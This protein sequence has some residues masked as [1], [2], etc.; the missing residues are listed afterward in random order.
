MSDK[1][2]LERY[3]L[4]LLGLLCQPTLV[5]L[6]LNPIFYNHTMLYCYFDNK[7]WDYELF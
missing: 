3:Q 4:I 6:S 1:C 5:H 2:G 7:I